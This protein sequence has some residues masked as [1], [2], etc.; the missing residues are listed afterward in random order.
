[1][2]PIGETTGAEAGGMDDD[3]SAAAGGAAGKKG[4]YV[5]PALRGDRPAGE[6]MG[7][8][9]FGER[10]DLATLRV[11]NVSNIQI[12]TCD[13]SLLTLGNRCPSW[14]RKESCEI[15]LSASAVSQECSS[16]RIGRP[17]WPRALRSSASPTVPMLS[18]PVPRWTATASSISF[19]GWSLPKRLSK[20]FRSCHGLV[21]GKVMH[22]MRICTR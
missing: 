14:P 6:R 20:P 7:G 16:L 8:S 17:G 15:C 9:K 5:P 1:M 21:R 22:G 2:A 11:T 4:S 3:V 13:E 10:D 12:L 18:R 19:S